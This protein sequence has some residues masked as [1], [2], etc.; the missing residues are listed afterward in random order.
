MTKSGTD[1][2]H[3]SGFYYRRDGS[4]N[5][6]DFFSGEKDEAFKQDQIGGVIGGPVVPSKA[7]FF[8]SYEWQNSP[9]TCSS[10]S[11]IVAIDNQQVGCGDERNL[12]F[13]RGDVQITS[14]H[15]AAIRYNKATR[16]RPHGTVGGGTV[17]GH[18]IDFD[19]DFDRYNFSLDSVIGGNKVNRLMYNN[20]NTG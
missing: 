3:G 1:A 12:W 10:N 14:N 8:V 17:P 18:S 7:F 4:W 6:P 15:R 5:S 9:R 2:F 20:L 11:G 16:L 13:L 19:F